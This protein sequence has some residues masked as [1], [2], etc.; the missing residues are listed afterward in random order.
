M[1]L[2]KQRLQELAAI[3]N[4]FLREVNASPASELLSLLAAPEF[5]KYK[6]QLSDMVE[7]VDFMKIDKLYTTLYAELKKHE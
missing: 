1:K 5:I 3:N 4:P 7:D 6:D 2:T